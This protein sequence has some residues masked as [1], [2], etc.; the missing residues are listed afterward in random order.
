LANLQTTR[1]WIRLVRIVLPATVLLVILAIVGTQNLIKKVG[2]V[3]VSNTTDLATQ[4]CSGK[5]KIKNGAAY[6]SVPHKIVLAEESAVVQQKPLLTSYDSVGLVPEHTPAGA[7]LYSQYLN[8]YSTSDYQDAQLVGCISR[9]SETNTGKT[10]TYDTGTLAVYD[11]KY[12]LN[13]YQ[14]RTRKLVKSTDLTTMPVADFGCPTS[15]YYDR[16]AKR[17]Y[18]SYDNTQVLTLAATLAESK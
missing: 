14:P 9:V 16:A 10:C 1:Q 8:Q 7:K 5:Q 12:H 2:G 11:A 18:V 17:Q 3:D 13:V 4:V 15:V 6:K